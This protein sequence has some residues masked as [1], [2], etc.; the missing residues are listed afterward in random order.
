MGDLRTSFVEVHGTLA[1]I[2][3]KIS[4]RL[5]SRQRRAIA[6]ALLR[7]VRPL[8]EH[9]SGGMIRHGEDSTDFR[10]LEERGLNLFKSSSPCS[11]NGRLGFAIRMRRLEL[12]LSL[13]ALS[14]RAGLSVDQISRIERGLSRPQRRTL[15]SLG[16]ALGNDFAEE[17]SE[18]S[19]G[20]SSER[21]SGRSPDKFLPCAPGNPVRIKMS[22]SRIR[23]RD[24]G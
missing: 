8:L 1:R 22:K 20:Q 18:R 23:P 10:R 6:V 21:S 11:P 15:Q 19:P 12:G 9:F 17:I 5:K 24:W 4:G 7:Q 3:I 2:S 13:R 14:S 16:K